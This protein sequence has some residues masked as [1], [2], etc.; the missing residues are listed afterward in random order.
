MATESKPPA[1]EGPILN[2]V[3][4]RVALGPLRE[5]LLPLYGR[6]TNDF[7]AIGMS[8]PRGLLRPIR[9]SED[10]VAHQRPSCTHQY[11]PKLAK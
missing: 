1:R 8:R 3:G 2:V 7:R 11:S 6:W 4:E 9:R 10:G 5:E